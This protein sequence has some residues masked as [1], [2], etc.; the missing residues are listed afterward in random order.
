MLK[1]YN[2]K[3]N[4]RAMQHLINQLEEG[5]TLAARVRARA[6]LSRGSLLVALPEGTYPSALLN[7]A[8]ALNLPSDFSY[9]PA[10]ASVAKAFLEDP[11]HAVLLQDVD[12]SKN[13]PWLQTYKWRNH[14]I[15][16]KSELYW[17]L[18]GPE[19]SV[20]EIVGI[21][22]S[23]GQFPFTA[24]FYMPGRQGVKFGLDDTDLDEAVSTLVGIVV[25]AFDE[26]SFLLWWSDRAPLPLRVETQ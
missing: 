10:L 18:T 16:Y 14:A 1:L 20:Q 22:D 5:T 11:K 8:E 15:P 9:F 25:G 13:D 2:I 19:L 3:D 26:D 6:D 7:V 23:A 24:F 21:F 12:A 17:Q 4:P